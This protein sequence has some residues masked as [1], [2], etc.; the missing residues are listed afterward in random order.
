MNPNVRCPAMGK[1]GCWSCFGPVYLCNPQKNTKCNKRGCGD[2]CRH[3][4]NPEFS[5]DRVPLCPQYKFRHE[6]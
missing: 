5:M 1:P 2:P 6:Q 3:T 4:L